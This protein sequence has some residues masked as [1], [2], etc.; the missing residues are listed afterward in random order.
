MHLLGLLVQWALKA[1]KRAQRFKGVNMGYSQWQRHFNN[2]GVMMAKSKIPTDHPIQEIWRLNRLDIDGYIELARGGD[3]DA[4]KCIMAKYAH[5]I[6]ME[7][8]DRASGVTNM[9]AGYDEYKAKLENYVLQSIRDSLK[10]G[11]ADYGFNFDHADKS[12]PKLTF[13]QKL[14][15]CSIAYQIAKIRDSTTS[16]SAAFDI[17]E[18]TLGIKKSQARALYEKY[19]RRAKK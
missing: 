3:T 9:T 17:A 14:D 1:T 15:Q 12:R 19:M 18:N 13:R 2:R 4:A 8:L 10:T 6:R 11:S 7:Q 5:L 16:D